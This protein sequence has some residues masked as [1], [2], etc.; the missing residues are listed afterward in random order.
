MAFL[1]G[2]VREM[3]EK[4]IMPI[5]TGKPTISA[6]VIGASAVNRMEMPD[7]GWKSPEFKELAMRGEYTLYVWG[8]AWYS[9]IFEREHFSTFCVLPES[10]NSRLFSFSPYGND[11]DKTERE[12]NRE[13]P[14]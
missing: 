8:E 5:S 1:D 3:A 4:G 11:I 10:T 12:E 14:N 6:A 9:D 7:I 2:E 13:N